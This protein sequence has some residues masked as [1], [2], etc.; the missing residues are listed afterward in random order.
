MKL[1]N[2]QMKFNVEL[3]SSDLGLISLV[4][5]MYATEMEKR[6]K[7]IDHDEYPTLVNF[8]NRDIR[9]AKRLVEAL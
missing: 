2:G 1:V 6:V 4:L 5:E 8:M 7:Q 9:D 3:S